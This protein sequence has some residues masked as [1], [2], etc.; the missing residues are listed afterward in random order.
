[1]TIKTK[2]IYQTITISHYTRI[3][4]LF[5]YVCFNAFCLQL[6]TETP[7]KDNSLKGDISYNLHIQKYYSFFL[8]TCND[9]EA[10]MF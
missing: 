9:A 2:I 1:M 10:K 4:I 6:L 3:G 5:I 8:K 7:F